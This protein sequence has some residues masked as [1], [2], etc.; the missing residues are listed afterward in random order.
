MSGD[1]IPFDFELT[2]EQVYKR[3]AGRSQY[4]CY[5]SLRCSIANRRAIRQSRMD[6]ILAQ[7]DALMFDRAQY[8]QKMGKTG[9][10][11]VST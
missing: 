2:H 10:Q 7:V 5:L 6:S 1:R 3:V 9:G 4:S 11:C 8:L